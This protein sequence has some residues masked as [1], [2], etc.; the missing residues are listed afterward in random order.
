MEA[1]RESTQNKWILRETFFFFCWNGSYTF[2]TQLLSTGLYFRNICKSHFNKS[3]H[4]LIYL[5]LI[6]KKYSLNDTVYSRYGFKTYKSHRHILMN[7]FENLECWL[8][9]RLGNQQW[10]GIER[11]IFYKDTIDP[12]RPTINHKVIIDSNRSTINHKFTIDPK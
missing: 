10:N 4:H 2:I 3:L 5:Q 7:S 1:F 8:Q 12:N 9:R 6:K 11:P